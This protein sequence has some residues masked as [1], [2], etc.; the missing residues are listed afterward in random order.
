V[1]ITA[2]SVHSCA[3]TAAGEAYC[4]GRNTYGQVG[5]GTRTDRSAPVRVQARERFVALRASGSHTCGTTASHRNVC[6]GY[7]IDG[8]LGD[9]TR[10]HRA[11][12]VPVTIGG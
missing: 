5:D 3:L 12:P 8:Q 10:T 7:N 9:G 4:W 6:W 11:R 2:G 1:R